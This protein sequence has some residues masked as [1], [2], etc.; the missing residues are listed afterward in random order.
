MTARIYRPLRVIAHRGYSAKYSEN[1]LVAFEA[2]VHA[3]ADAIE[4]DVRLTQDDV[5]VVI[6]DDRVDRTTAGS[7]P[8]AAHTAE[9]IRALG[10]PTLEEVFALVGKRIVI[11]VEVK[12]EGAAGPVEALVRRHGLEATVFLSSFAPPFLEGLSPDLARALLV[13]AVGE[14]E[15]VIAAA[16]GLGA[17]AVSP[18][19][20]GLCEADVRTFAS[21]HLMVLPHTVDDPDR[22]RRLLEGGADGLITNDPPGLRRV[23]ETPR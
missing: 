19:A 9:A 7:G 11:D 13:E 20:K 15:A 12:V 17:F 8:V 6:H 21:R 3:D 14:P 18:Q 16:R 1:T 4:L 5:P 2:A 10:V 23:L 22:M